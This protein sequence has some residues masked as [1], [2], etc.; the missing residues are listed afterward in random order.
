MNECIRDLLAQDIIARSD[1]LYLSSVVLVKKANGT[2]RICFE[3][4]T[5]NKHILDIPLAPRPLYDIL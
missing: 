5:L 2:P 3:S 1:S 4:R